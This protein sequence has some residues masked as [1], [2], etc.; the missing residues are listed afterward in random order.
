MKL[1]FIKS[2][3]Q[4]KDYPD[5][6]QAEVAIIGR[7]NAGKSSFINALALSKLAKVS[8]QPGKTRLLNFFAVG[9]SY[10][11]VDMPGYGF[12][13]RSAN[14][15]KSWQKMIETYIR[16][17]P[18]LVGCLL[19]MDLRRKWTDDEQMILEWLLQEDIPLAVILNKIDKSKQQEKIVK[20]RQIAEISGVDHVFLASSLKRQG[21]K[22]VEN[23]VFANWIKKDG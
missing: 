16:T 14:E 17:R 2:A 21:V 9:E 1:N 3:V 22:E 5:E 18:N 15:L 6:N 8:Q 13:A 10:R 20:K 19:I 11:L 7:S 12:A 4:I 23:W